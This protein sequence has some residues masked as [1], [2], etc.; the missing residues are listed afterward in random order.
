MTKEINLKWITKV[1]QRGESETIDIQFSD[2]NV[3]PE[4]MIIAIGALVSKVSEQTGVDKAN[5][6]KEVKGLLVN[7]KHI[8]RGTE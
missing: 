5:I 1:D 2:G 7:N 3:F 8:V 6:L 4:D